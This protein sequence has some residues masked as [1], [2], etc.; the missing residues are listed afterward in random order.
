MSAIG[1]IFVVLNLVFSLVIVGAAASYLSKADDWRG[2][3]NELNATYQDEKGLWEQESS[4]QT[5]RINTIGVA[6]PGFS[7]Q[8]EP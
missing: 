6:C 4:D 2:Q 5:A 3:Y 7:R 1:K 8:G